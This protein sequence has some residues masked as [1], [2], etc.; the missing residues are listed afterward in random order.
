MFP[1]I[2]T[3]LQASSTVRAIFGARPRVYRQGEAPQ[4]PPPKAG[5]SQANVKPYAT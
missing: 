1:P 5:E 3:T 4:L 2:Y